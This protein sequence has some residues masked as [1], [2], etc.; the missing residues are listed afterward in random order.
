MLWTISKHNSRNQL[1]KHND[2][3]HT[4]PPIQKTKF[5]LYIISKHDYLQLFDNDGFI[6][7]YY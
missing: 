6:M 3:L 2:C 7:D 4:G 1:Y 5:L